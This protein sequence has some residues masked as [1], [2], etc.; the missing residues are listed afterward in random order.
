MLSRLHL[1]TIL[2]IAAVLWGAAL[3]FAG[4][5]IKVTWFQPFSVVV[6]VLVLILAAFDLW[7]W[8]MS[9][10]RGWFVHRP[11]IRGTWKAI[12]QSQWTDPQTGK[13]PPAIEA[14][15]AIRQ[16]YSMLSMRLMTEESTSEILG[17]EMVRAPDDTYRVA[18]VYRNEPRLSVR[19][20]SPIHY[21]AVLLQVE[22]DPA[23]RLAGHYWTD[24]SSRG[25]VVASTH[26]ATVFPNF[27]AACRGLSAKNLPAAQ[28]PQPDEDTKGAGA[29]TPPSKNDGTGG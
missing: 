14:Y 20:R 15:I 18:G 24:R 23:S 13:A 1:S 5:A 26:S 21:G 11:C 2:V 29:G 10:L 9:W 27:D 19:E 28:P 4:V 25:E 3:L 16:T 8:R 22:G 7:L 6:G 17:A 12:L